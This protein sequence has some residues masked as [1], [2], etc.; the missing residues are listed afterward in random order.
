MKVLHDLVLIKP[1]KEEESAIVKP[2]DSKKEPQEGTVIEIGEDT[3]FVK[4]GDEVIYRRWSGD[5]VED[6][7][8]KTRS[9]III[10]E[11]DV[12]IIKE[13]K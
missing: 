3:R 9:F 2:K 4:V 1:E 12:L 11:E 13:D 8:D 10:K 5:L 6:D 7:K